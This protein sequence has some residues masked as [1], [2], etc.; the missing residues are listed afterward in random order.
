MAR[1]IPFQEEG[2]KGRKKPD[3][4]KETERMARLFL[5]KED[6]TQAKLRL[7]IVQ[8]R[9]SVEWSVLRRLD[10]VSWL[11][12]RWGEERSCLY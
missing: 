11:L 1:Y 9:F 2:P 12:S 5:G 3:V 8:V 6:D 7:K 10:W 4:D